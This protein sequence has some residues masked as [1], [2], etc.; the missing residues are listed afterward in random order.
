M[1]AGMNTPAP[2]RVALVGCGNIAGPYA[3]DIV[4]YP[5]LALVGVADQD[6]ARAA[7][8]AA[9]HGTRAY[10][11]VDALLAD[12]QV[13]LV[14]NLTTHHAHY[15]VT[16]QCLQAGKH[17]YSEKPLA[18]TYAEAAGLVALAAAR[19]LRLA[20]SP[21]TIMGEAQQTA[22]RWLREGR[23]GQVRVVFAEVNW[24]R[25]EEWHPAPAAFYDVGPLFDV[26]VYPLAI[27]TA[28]FGPARRVAAYGT[29]LHPDRVTKEGVPFRVTTPDFM[30]A[31]LE[32]RTGPVVRLTSDFYVAQTSTRQTGIEFHGDLGS[33]HLESWLG[34][35]SPV[36]FA[37][38]G[39]PFAPVPLVRDP[40]PGI[41]WGRGVWDTATALR[42]GRPHRLTGEQAAHITE[43]L[44]AVAE[45]ARAGAPVAL[46]SDFPPPTPLEWA[47]RDE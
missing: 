43:I 32:F 41:P 34:F 25:I 31:V 22:W 5:E 16:R 18:L 28:I 36:W 9:E 35:D 46:T 26:G 19:G 12:P 27:L 1:V 10:S 15:S 42:A 20:C 33:L 37:P 30:V 6:A 11:S 39:Q 2:V 40:S 21:F 24:G 8:F 14:V 13:E 3:E 45:S 38:F 7:T 4:T 29:V 17:V 44:G 23:L 47:A